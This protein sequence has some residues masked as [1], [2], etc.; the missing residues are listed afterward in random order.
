VKFVRQGEKKGSGGET[1]EQ[2]EK[3]FGGGGADER[4]K[5]THCREAAI[6]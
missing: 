3:D 2:K 4:K 6:I 5:G 1:K